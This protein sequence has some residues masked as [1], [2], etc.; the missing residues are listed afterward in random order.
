MLI[1]IKYYNKFIKTWKGNKISKLKKHKPLLSNH[2]NKF[3][4]R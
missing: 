4:I 2:D 1:T 3:F